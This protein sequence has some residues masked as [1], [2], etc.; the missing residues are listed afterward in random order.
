MNS[1]GAQAISPVIAPGARA[2]T[3]TDKIVRA[4]R[5]A[6]GSVARH[7]QN[8]PRLWRGRLVRQM[9]Q[10]RLHLGDVRGLKTFLSTLNIKLN[11]VTFLQ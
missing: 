6:L 11:A 7:K 1:R 5:S 8:R 9:A 4:P 10:S 2:V 3:F